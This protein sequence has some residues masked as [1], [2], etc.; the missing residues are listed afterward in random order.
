MAEDEGAVTEEAPEGVA[1][2]ETEAV[3]AEEASEVATR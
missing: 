2:E 1:G 3:E